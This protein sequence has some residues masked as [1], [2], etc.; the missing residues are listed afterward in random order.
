MLTWHILIHMNVVTQKKC[1]ISGPFSEN[2]RNMLDVAG[3]SFTEGIDLL[4]SFSLAMALR[5]F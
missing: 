2:F 3:W 5:E 1:W 4:K